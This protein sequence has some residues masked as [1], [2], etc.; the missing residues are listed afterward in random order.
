MGFVGVGVGCVGVG[1]GKNFVGGNELW[2]VLWV[3]PT[4]TAPTGQN[5]HSHPQK[6]HYYL[7][8]NTL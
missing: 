6:Q 5:P 2:V 8:P 3:Y 1:V 7:V 4:P